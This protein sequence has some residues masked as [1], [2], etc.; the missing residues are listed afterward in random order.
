MWAGREAL[1]PV[2]GGS[3]KDS[4]GIKMQIWNGYQ[5]NFFP[6]GVAEIEQLEKL[7]YH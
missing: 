2:F 3:K 6:H 5:N 7:D 1:G 4:G